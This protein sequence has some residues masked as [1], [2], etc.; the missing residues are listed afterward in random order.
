VLDVRNH[1]SS[2]SCITI[3]ANATMAIITFVSH[4]LEQTLAVYIGSVLA[5]RHGRVGRIKYAPENYQHP[6]S[7]LTCSQRIATSPQSQRPGEQKAEEHSQIKILCSDYKVVYFVPIVSRG[8]MSA[9][10]A[11]NLATK[12]T[13]D[14]AI[15]V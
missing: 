7:S 3:A 5:N 8:Q 2:M 12:A 11:V 14:S 4:A 9:T 10:G 6:R 13:G 1:I 15:I